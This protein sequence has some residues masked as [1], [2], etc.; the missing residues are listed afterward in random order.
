MEF[1][2]VKTK[3]YVTSINNILTFLHYFVDQTTNLLIKKV[4]ERLI[5]Y[6]N[7]CNN[8]SCNPI[9]INCIK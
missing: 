9:F 5:D 1:F 3:I 7:D 4:I 6:E 8:P 2:E